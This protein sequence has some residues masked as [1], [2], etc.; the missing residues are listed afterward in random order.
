[1][2]R[3]AKKRL[4]S[5]LLIRPIFR[6]TYREGGREFGVRYAGRLKTV[7]PVFRRPFLTM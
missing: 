2:S 5:C 3:E 1:M 4:V 6:R 7:H